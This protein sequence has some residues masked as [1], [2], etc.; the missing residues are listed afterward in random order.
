MI[1]TLLITTAVIGSLCAMEDMA[2]YVKAPH[3]TPSLAPQ[4]SEETGGSLA[5][6][7]LNVE[8]VNKGIYDHL[9]EQYFEAVHQ[10]YLSHTI[11]Y[12]EIY[13]TYQTNVL[14][15]VTHHPAMQ[16]VWKVKAI[17]EDEPAPYIEWA[18]L[19]D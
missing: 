1:K 18:N 13:L 19:V 4:E 3:T 8:E 17:K 7:S 2:Y 14:D 10:L 9:V 15:Q 5:P 6:L 11:H 12:H 16:Y